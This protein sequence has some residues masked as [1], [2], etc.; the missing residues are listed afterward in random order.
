M[1]AFL[2]VELNVLDPD[3]LKEYGAQT[4]E[5]LK[6]FDGEVLV[7]GKPALLHESREEAGAYETMV[8]FQ[9][10]DR[11]AA[12]AWYDS[13]EYQRLIPVRDKAISSRFRLIG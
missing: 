11:A 3:A 6:R 10:P 7:K 9:F 5:I 8:V 1:T 12:Q 13:D 2:I 4:P